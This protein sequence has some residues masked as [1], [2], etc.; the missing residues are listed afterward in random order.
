MKQKKCKDCGALKSPDAFYG[1]QGECKECTKAR[2]KAYRL[3]N[4]EVVRAY[5]RKR[6]HTELR[7]QK[8]RAAY[9]RMRSTEEGRAKE[10]ERS[11][12]YREKNKL[13]RAAHLLCQ[14][15]VNSGKLKRMPCERCHSEDHIHA[16]HEDYHMPLEVT[17][18]CRD[19]HGLRHRE[20]NQA[21]RA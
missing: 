19:C 6:G 21:K 20:I 5:D 9:V 7:K 13:A 3:D 11:R 10:N 8:N 16:H 15:A 12:K 2:V 18:L 17:W 4:L 1:V 14:N